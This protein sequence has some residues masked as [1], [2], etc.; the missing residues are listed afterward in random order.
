MALSQYDLLHRYAHRI[1]DPSVRDVLHA[2]I[3][4][5]ADKEPMTMADIQQ[6]LQDL[7][8]AVNGL[9]QRAAQDHSDLQ[10]QIDQLKQ[11]GVDTTQL[12][13]IADSI[14]GHV[15]TLNQIDPV[16]QVPTDGGTTGG[17]TDG[18]TTAPT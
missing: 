13:Q 6:A 7:G 9:A 11:S 4:L 5:L 17:T 14:E 8:D 12:Q 18:G 3:N 1:L 2:L 16:A 10:A 15:S